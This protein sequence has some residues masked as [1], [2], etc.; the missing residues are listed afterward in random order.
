MIIEFPGPAAPSH[1]AAHISYQGRRCR[2][3]ARPQYGAR[4]RPPRRPFRGTLA[5][6]R[7]GQPA[8]ISG[9]RRGRL[10][11]H[12]LGDGRIGKKPRT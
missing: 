3:R 7:P 11:G 1:A 5:E 9:G 8:P 10:Q 6:A 2:S 4:P 12:A